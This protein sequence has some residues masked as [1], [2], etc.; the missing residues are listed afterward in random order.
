MIQFQPFIESTMDFLKSH[1]F[2]MIATIVVLLSLVYLGGASIG[3]TI[4]E[5]IFY[6]THPN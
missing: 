6:I 2:F 5:A 4:G 1:P 3:K